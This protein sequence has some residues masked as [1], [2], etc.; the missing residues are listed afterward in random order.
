MNKMSELRT[1]LENLSMLKKSKRKAAKKH[2]RPKSGRRSNAS[3]SRQSKW[4][5]STT[6]SSLVKG[7][8]SIPLPPINGPNNSDATILHEDMEGNHLKTLF[9][10]DNFHSY[11]PLFHST[12]LFFGKIAYLLLT[13]LFNHRLLI[14]IY[15]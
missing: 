12:R 11:T 3:Q 4:S 10:F 5:A 7:Q 8:N 2:Q 1:Q 9:F 14:G 15:V 6:Q 13:H